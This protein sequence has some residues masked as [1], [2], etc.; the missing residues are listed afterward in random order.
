MSKPIHKP[1]NSTD[2]E[3]S[4]KTNTHARI[5]NNERK[6]KTRHIKN[7]KTQFETPIPYSLFPPAI[8]S[9]EQVARIRGPITLN[10][11]TEWITTY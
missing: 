2:D 11:Q 6:M 3:W 1:N 9:Y 10:S 4:F 5:E 7:A 8:P